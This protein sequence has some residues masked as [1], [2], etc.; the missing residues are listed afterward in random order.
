[1]SVELV[2]KKGRGATEAEKTAARPYAELLRQALTDGRLSKL[3]NAGA[4]GKAVPKK[5]VSEPR[6]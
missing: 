1:M 6:K 3:N 4:A 5:K 2:L